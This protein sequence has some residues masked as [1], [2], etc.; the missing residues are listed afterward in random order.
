VNIE[1]KS[2][3]EISE[4]KDTKHCGFVSQFLKP[5]EKNNPT[6]NREQMAIANL[7]THIKTLL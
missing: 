2:N 3:N 4:R 1:N 6:I 7:I 5:N